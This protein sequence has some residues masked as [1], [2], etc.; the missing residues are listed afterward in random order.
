MTHT[1]IDAIVLDDDLK[2][3]VLYHR[4]FSAYYQ[5]QDPKPVIDYDYEYPTFT[6]EEYQTEFDT[7]IQELHDAEDERLR[8]QDLRDRFAALSDMR[9]AFHA[10]RSESN[11]AK[12]LEDMVKSSDHAQA[13]A[14]MVALE[15]EDASQKTARDAVAYAEKRKAEYPTTDEL[16]V[17]M[18][19][20]D[21]ATIDALEAARQ[22]IKAKYPKPE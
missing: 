16:I 22:A 12:F 13:E 17:A 1:E 2:Q 15:A 8:Q 18:W 10:T 4:L 5:A 3:D 14:D 9:A 20:G 21:Q 6:D 7:Y 11:P 19:E